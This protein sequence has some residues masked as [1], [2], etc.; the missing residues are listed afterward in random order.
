MTAV[1]NNAL[2]TRS[3][4][5]AA[6]KTYAYYSLAKA[7]AHPGAV[8]RLPFSMKVLPENLLRFEATKTVTRA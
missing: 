8:S 5:T 4:L 7:A 3:T 6:G 2:N 1:G